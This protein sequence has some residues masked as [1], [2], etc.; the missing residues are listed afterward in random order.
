MVRKIVGAVILLVVAIS[1]Y[2]FLYEHLAGRWDTQQQLVWEGKEFDARLKMAN[3][4][5]EGVLIAQRKGHPGKMETAH[6]QVEQKGLGVASYTVRLEGELSI[7]FVMN[8]QGP[9]LLYCLDCP[10][11]R[12]WQLPFE[13]VILPRQ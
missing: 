12:V 3:N 1:G 2:G 7:D 8:Q 9:H 10:K 13:W 5:R 6:V 4:G 11:A